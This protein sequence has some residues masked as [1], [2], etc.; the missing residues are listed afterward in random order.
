RTDVQMRLD[1]SR[2]P[3][4]ALLPLGPGN[5]ASAVMR[6]LRHLEVDEYILACDSESAGTLTDIA[7]PWGFK[8][9]A[10]SRDDVLDRYIKAAENFDL[11]RLVRA[12]GDNP[13]VSTELAGQLLTTIDALELQGGRPVDYAG[14]VGMPLGMGV[15]LVRLSSLRKAAAESRDPYEHEHVCPY[16]Y[17]NPELFRLELFACPSGYGLAEVRL[18]VDTAEDY[19]MIKTIFDILGPDPSDAEVMAQLWSVRAEAVGSQG[20][21]K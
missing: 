12:T 5:L 10:G 2:L 14:H 6:R 15:E 11:D 8:V 21:G 16:L 18:T 1:S 17:R 9:F 3:R 19:R 4:K 20:R 7:K 13:L